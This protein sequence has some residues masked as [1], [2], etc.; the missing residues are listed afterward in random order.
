MEIQA[1]SFGSIGMAAEG[2]NMIV[3]VNV[4]AVTSATTLSKATGT[5]VG[6]AAPVQ[7]V[8]TEASL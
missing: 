8:I 4:G 1:Q 7:A 6:L 3:L 5:V 2:A